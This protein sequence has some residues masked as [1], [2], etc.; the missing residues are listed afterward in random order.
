MLRV[1]GDRVNLLGPHTARVFLQSEKP[2]EFKPS[3]DISFLMEA[4]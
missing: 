4:Y 3:D 2:M 1:H